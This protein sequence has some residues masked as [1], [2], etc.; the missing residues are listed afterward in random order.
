MCKKL[1]KNSQPFGKKF[2]KT[3]GGG[4]F[5]WL[6][7]YMYLVFSFCCL[8]FFLCSSFPSVLWYCWL[9]LLTCK[10]RRPYNPYCVGADVNYALSIY[11]SM[12]VPTDHGVRVGSTFVADSSQVCC[13]RSAAVTVNA[14][15]PEGGCWATDGW[16]NKSKQADKQLFMRL[17]HS[18]IKSHPLASSSPQHIIPRPVPEYTK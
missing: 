6:T 10:N 17:G 18:N 1:I 9:G 12:S 5:F 3:V 13:F 14:E 4:I 15:S 2:Q 16:N 8:G 7:L 11:L